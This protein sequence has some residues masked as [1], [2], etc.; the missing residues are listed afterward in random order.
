MNDTTVINALTDIIFCLLPI[1]VVLAL[2]INRRARVTLFLIL[3][4]GL[5]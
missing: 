5:L 2:R 4:L 1:P 3:S